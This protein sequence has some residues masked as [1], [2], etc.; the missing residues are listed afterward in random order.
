[1][2]FECGDIPNLDPEL[3]DY[4]TV[5]NV[6]NAER[7][8]LTAP[9]RWLDAGSDG[10]MQAIGVGTNGGKQRQEVV[11][12]LQGVVQRVATHNE[13]LSRAT[14]SQSVRTSLSPSA[15][16]STNPR[17]VSL[18]QVSHNAPTSPLA[19]SQ[20]PTDSQH[21][22]TPYASRASAEL[23]HSLTEKTAGLSVNGNAKQGDVPNAITMPP[24]PVE[25]GRQKTEYMTPA[26]EPSELKTLA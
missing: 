18:R 20:T 24:P 16:S 25:L 6:P 10:E 9:V 15:V 2:N 14:T 26:Q 1:M 23:E 11:A 7:L 12:T 17:P 13:R 5:S 8:F 4:L 19:N 22:A 21:I 3:R